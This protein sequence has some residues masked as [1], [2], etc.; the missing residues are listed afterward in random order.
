MQALVD[1]FCKASCLRFAALP[2][3][4]NTTLCSCPR[5]VL[6]QTPLLAHGQALCGKL[7]SKTYM[8]SKHSLCQRGEE[9][10]R[11]EKPQSTKTTSADGYAA[12]PSFYI[13]CP[14]SLETTCPLYSWST[15]MRHRISIQLKRSCCLSQGCGRAV[16][17][18]LTM[19]TPLVPRIWW[20]CHSGGLRFSNRVAT[21]FLKHACWDYCCSHGRDEGPAAGTGMPCRLC[22]QAYRLCLEAYRLCPRHA[23]YTHWHAACGL[24]QMLAY[25]VRHAGCAQRQACYARG[26]QVVPRGRSAVP[27]ARR[28]CPEACR[29]CPEACRLCPAGARKLS[30]QP[31]RRS[32]QPL[33]CV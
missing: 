15:C 32:P 11:E 17:V 5:P 8:H 13:A 19:V 10:R 28:L 1:L 24:C 25:C 21:H 33:S 27:E 23:G 29:L 6:P 18:G 4:L 31:C 14:L 22:P 7:S 3:H 20:R 12:Q 9:N 30:S 2:Q 26:M 16:L